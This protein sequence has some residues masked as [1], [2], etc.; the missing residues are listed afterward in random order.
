MKTNRLPFFLP[1]LI[2]VLL[3]TT[4][5]GC[6][7]FGKQQDKEDCWTCYVDFPNGE[8]DREA[9]CNSAEEA[10]FLSRHEGFSPYCY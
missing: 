8:R 7:L 2:L 9:V 1:V 6:C 3:S 10:E 4:L 5:S